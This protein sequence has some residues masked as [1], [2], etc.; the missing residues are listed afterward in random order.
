MSKDK[1]TPTIFTLAAQLRTLAEVNERLQERVS[2]LESVA[3]A[4]VRTLNLGAICDA[5]EFDAYSSFEV[6]EDWSYSQYRFTKG[7][8]VRADQMTHWKDFVKHGLKL[9]RPTNQDDLIQK[10]KED[11]NVLLANANAQAIAAR[12]AL[13]EADALAAKMSLEPLE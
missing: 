10:I 6:L 2:V 5:I 12:T 9:A 13:A 8:V 11:T 4:S 3:P 1:E 7:Q